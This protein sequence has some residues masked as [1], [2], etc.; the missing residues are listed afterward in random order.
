MSAATGKPLRRLSYRTAMSIDWSPDS[1]RI[2]FTSLSRADPYKGDVYVVR[3]NGTGLRRLT[4]TPNV[5]ETD[6]V[7]SPDGSRIAFVRDVTLGPPLTRYPR[8][9]QAIWTMGPDGTAQR[10]I[11]KPWVHDDQDGRAQMRISWQ[12]LPRR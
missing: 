4:S 2:V 3:A 10:R 11:R 12:P 5:S 9:A 7:W 6:A 8:I 1:K